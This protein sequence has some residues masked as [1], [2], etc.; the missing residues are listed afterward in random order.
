MALGE[1]PKLFIF[2]A[3]EPGKAD[4]KRL[5]CA[6][7]DAAAPVRLRPLLP[8]S[9]CFGPS[10]EPSEPIHPWNGRRC[11]VAHQVISAD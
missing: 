3:V 6:D 10:D 11:P 7:I 2:G 8:S 4:V 9:I 1:A 5:A